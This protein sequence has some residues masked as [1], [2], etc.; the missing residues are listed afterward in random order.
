MTRKNR[1]SSNNDRNR[2]IGNNTANIDFIDDEVNADDTTDDDDNDDEPHRDSGISPSPYDEDDELMYPYASYLKSALVTL[3][4]QQVVLSN[5]NGSSSSRETKRKSNKIIIQYSSVEYAGYPGYMSNELFELVCRGK[6][7]RKNINY[8]G[9][10]GIYSNSKTN[11]SAASI[12][13]DGGRENDDHVRNSILS[14][15]T[16]SSDKES[17]T[18]T[19]TTTT[20]IGIL[21]YFAGSN[22]LSEPDKR[23]GDKIFQNI[24]GVHEWAKKYSYKWNSLDL[25][26]KAKITQTKINQLLNDYYGNDNNGGSGSGSDSDGSGPNTSSD[27]T[28]VSAA[29]SAS[30]T[31]S[32]GTTTRSGTTVVEF[33]FGYSNNDID[34]LWSS[35]LLHL[36][37]HGYR[38]L[39]KSLASTIINVVQK[40]INND[41]RK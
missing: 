21:I 4:Q 30:S 29:A 3:Q 17:D 26:K 12:I 37:Q 14:L 1:A 6:E 8:Y 23:Q 38:V 40:Q 13:D 2:M 28:S 27:N 20:T 41:Y 22:D 39:G 31:T 36:S 19:T 15:S 10:S 9:S 11:T 16:P 32:S 7:E 34:G 18:T 25:V 35:D 24:V 5:D 33:P